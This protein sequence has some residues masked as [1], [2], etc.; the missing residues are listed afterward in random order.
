MNLIGQLA[1]AGPDHLQFCDLGRRWL[2]ISRSWTTL[3]HSKTL[4][5]PSTTI[6]PLKA[7]L[8]PSY[9][10]LDVPIDNYFPCLWTLLWLATARPLHSQ[11]MTASK[12]VRDSVRPASAL[13]TGLQAPCGWEGSGPAGLVQERLCGHMPGPLRLL[14]GQAKGCRWALT[15]TSSS[16]S[17]PW[18]GCGPHDRASR[19]HA[20]AGSRHRS[21]GRRPRLR[22]RTSC[23]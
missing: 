22:N 14:G 16:T 21:S 6:P 13:T 1:A 4:H 19:C 9:R 8:C 15:T 10:V 23:C 5:G 17:G 2:S 3:R 7:L 20:W 11:A 12:G 18:L